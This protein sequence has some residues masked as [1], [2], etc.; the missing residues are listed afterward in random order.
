M[1]RS[2]L[3]PQLTALRL[4]GWIAVPLQQYFFTSKPSVGNADHVID[5]GCCAVELPACAVVSAATGI[6]LNG[7]QVTQQTLFSG[8][9][10]AHPLLRHI[11][12]AV[13]QRCPKLR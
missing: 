1:Q 4:P 13:P 11:R 5:F 7:C 12:L 6:F 10:H 9:N 2:A 8:V 3:A